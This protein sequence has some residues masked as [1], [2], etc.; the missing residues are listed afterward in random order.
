MNE[1]HTLQ[2]EI[3]ILD[4]VNEGVFTVDKDWRITALNRAA[5]Q[6]TG[7]P[8]DQALGRACC[9][10]FRANICERDCALRRTMDTGQ[11]VVNATAYI[12]N[13]QEIGRASCRERV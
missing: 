2:R 11:P 1:Q 13:H 4:S 6:I 12:V 8:R 7:V 10:V 9:D 5:E 3:T